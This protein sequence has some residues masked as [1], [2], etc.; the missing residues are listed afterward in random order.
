[1]T[2]AGGLGPL[3]P[4]VELASQSQGRGVRVGPRGQ[5]AGRAPHPAACPRSS[6][7][8]P[9]PYAGQAGP[10]AD[11]AGGQREGRQ[12]PGN[13]GGQ[14][15]LTSHWAHGQ[16]AGSGFPCGQAGGGPPRQG[17]GGGRRSASAWPF[18]AEE[19]PEQQSTRLQART[20]TRARRCA[21]G[22]W[23]DAE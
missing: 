12:R 11:S 21:W 9:C 7:A 2:G 8:V 1:M 14:G 6:P 20:R 18:P 3:S 4:Y 22:P 15:T 19:R 17:H 5:G 16:C 23:W 13:A 10:M